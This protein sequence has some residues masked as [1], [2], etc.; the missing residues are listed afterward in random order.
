VE[1]SDQNAVLDKHVPFSWSSLVVNALAAHEIRERTVI[2]NVQE[3]WPDAPPDVHQLLHRLVFI[4]K[5]SLAQMAEG[6]V[7]E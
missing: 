4:Q 3:V 7:R 1:V 2:D 6:L 5:I